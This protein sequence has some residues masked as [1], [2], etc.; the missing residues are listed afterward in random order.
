MNRVTNEL[1]KKQSKN[2]KGKAH[3]KYTDRDSAQ[4]Q[5]IRSVRGSVFPVCFLTSF[6]QRA[7]VPRSLLNILEPD[8]TGD[9]E[10][11][12]KKR[13]DSSH[14]K[15]RHSSKNSGQERESSS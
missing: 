8:M 7:A 4:P 9:G 14:R 2:C 5:S 12:K 15:R 11:G 13:R 6:L 10:A 3:D 1:Q